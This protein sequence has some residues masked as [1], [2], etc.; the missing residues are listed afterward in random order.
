M[1]TS[2]LIP[3]AAIAALGIGAYFLL[4]DFK[5]GDL[6]GTPLIMAGAA[7]ETIK[8]TGVVGGVGD[9]IYN[10]G[11]GGDLRQE[12]TKPEG[13]YY[14]A[15]VAETTAL[16]RQVKQPD[17]VI[18]KEAIVHR[19]V[20]MGTAEKIHDVGFFETLVLG[21]IPSVA[22][23]PIGAGFAAIEKQ[24][25]YVEALPTP[26]LKK[27][28]LVK[29]Y[30]TRQAW[31][32]KHSVESMIGFPALIAHAVTAPTEQT[33]FFSTMARGWGRIFG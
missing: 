9:I 7:P 32:Q 12:A 19:A 33:D 20:A 13:T 30:A 17:V 22:G 2:T 23:V 25:K 5:L 16:K 4:K 10:I 11:Y 3:I 31:V 27:A 1:K 15:A 26:E 6:F 24:R 14:K 8:E 28:A 29:E 18:P 21:A